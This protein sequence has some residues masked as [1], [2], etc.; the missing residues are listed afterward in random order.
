MSNQYFYGVQRPSLLTQRRQELEQYNPPNVVVSSVG[1]L[2]F[3]QAFRLRLKIEGA[4]DRVARRKL[5][6]HD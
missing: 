4:M 6:H 1:V 3:V 5:A 2:S